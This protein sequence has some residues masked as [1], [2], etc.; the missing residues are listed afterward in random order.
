[1]YFIALG[2]CDMLDLILI[3][4]VGILRNFTGENNAGMTLLLTIMQSSYVHEKPEKIQLA[5]K[6]T[7]ELQKKVNFDCKIK[8][9][10]EN[11]ERKYVEKLRFT[12]LPYM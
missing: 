5:L 4:H 3:A 8:K 11:S 1:M 9:I 12:Q 7:E 2:C 6:I 10:P